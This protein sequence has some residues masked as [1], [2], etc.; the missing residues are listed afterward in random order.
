MGNIK[1]WVMV[2]LL[3]YLE[4][5]FGVHNCYFWYGLDLKVVLDLR[6]VLDWKLVMEDVNGYISFGILSNWVG[7]SKFI[8]FIKF[9]FY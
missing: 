2:N 8:L 7:L 3:H 6:V 9:Y 5:S 4:W 1:S